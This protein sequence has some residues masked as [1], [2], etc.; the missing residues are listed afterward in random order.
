[1]KRIIALALI[2]SMVLA[3]P[4]L[5][6]DVHQKAEVKGKFSSSLKIKA[7]SFIN[8][9]N[10]FSVKGMT[11]HNCVGKVTT[12]IQGVAGVKSVKV[13]L[14]NDTA[15]VEFEKNAKVKDLSAKLVKAVEKAGYK[16]SKI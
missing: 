10:V 12:A 13:S 14:D 6:C 7:K 11:C 9:A 8:N 3:L 16:A 4:T 1:M 2:S 5:A 15:T